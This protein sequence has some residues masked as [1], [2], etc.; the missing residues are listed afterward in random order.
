[1]NRSQPRHFRPIFLLPLYPLIPFLT[2]FSATLF[3]S[4]Q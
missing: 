1:M 4:I 2:H 3:I